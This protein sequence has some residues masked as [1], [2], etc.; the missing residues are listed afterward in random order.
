MTS[1]LSCSSNTTSR[2]LAGRATDAPL[3]FLHLLRLLAAERAWTTGDFHAA[4]LAFNAARRRGAGGSGS[5][6]WR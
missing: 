2:W 1:G 4:A 6:T 3:N 5:G